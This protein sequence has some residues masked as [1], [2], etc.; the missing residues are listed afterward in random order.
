[1]LGAIYTFFITALVLNGTV[2]WDAW[3]AQIAALVTAVV[4]IAITVSLARRGVFGWRPALD[5][6]THRTEIAQ[7]M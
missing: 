3:Q 4:M 2:I 5:A 1:L 7:P 6:G